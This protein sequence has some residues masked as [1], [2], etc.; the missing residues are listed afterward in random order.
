MRHQIFK[1]IILK[2]KIIWIENFK[3]YI[4]TIFSNFNIE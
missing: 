2:F 1:L 3:F 4:I